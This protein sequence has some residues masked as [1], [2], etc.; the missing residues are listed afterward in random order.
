MRKRSEADATWNSL[1]RRGTLGRRILFWLLVLSLVPLLLSTTLGYVVSRRILEGQARKFLGAIAETQAE[2]VAVE[3]VRHGLSLQAL[4]AGSRAIEEYLEPAAAAVRRGLSDDPAAN[5]LERLLEEELSATGVFDELA[6]LGPFGHLLAATDG[7]PPGVDWSEERFF[8]AS[9]THSVITEWWE[10][11]RLT[12][13]VT[14][15]ILGNDDTRRAVLVALTRSEN[16]SRLLQV[17]L[18]IAGFVETYIVAEDGSP[19]F[20]S[21]A[22]FPFDSP[23]PFSSPLTGARPGSALTYTNFRGVEVVAASAR[24]PGLSWLSITEAPVEAVFGQLREL[25]VLAGLIEF[26]FALFLVA[27]VW[28]TARSIVTPVRLLVAGADRIR[29]GELGAQVAVHRD[30]ELGQLGRTFNQ[31]SRELQTSAS[32]IREL[33]EQEMRRAAQLA[34]VGELASGIAHE[35]K[36]PVAGIASGIDLLV[37]R[38]AEDAQTESIVSQVRSQLRRIET[39]INDLLSYAEPKRPR[40]VRVDPTEVVDRAMSLVRTQA[41]V[42][43]LR[44]GTQVP[45]TCLTVEADPEQLTQALVNL[46]VNGMQAMNE[47]GDL[48]VSV[49]PSDGEVRIEVADTGTGIPADKIQEIFRPFVTTKH[50]G[51]GLGLAITRG[52]VERNG[53]RIEVESHVGAGSRFT[54]VLPLCAAELTT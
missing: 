36:N 25:R 7:V 14:L 30:D 53:G 18:Q 10:G 52:I 20:V 37:A 24:I 23:A 35:I 1:L 12:Y 46:L 13:V 32:Q 21:D 11:T 31:M 22:E 27:I 33:H 41:E 34:S 19:L 16:R 3:M 9:R 48:L 4:F 6:L 43:G 51:T 17:P 54:I 49:A 50:R 2:H 40:V 45:G 29:E 5:E 8:T 26:V 38:S 44:L 28:L 47:S 42:A 15:P 39:A